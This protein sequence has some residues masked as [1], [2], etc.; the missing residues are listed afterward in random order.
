MTQPA[1]YANQFGNVGEFTN[2]QMNN[3]DA[4]AVTNTGSD[5]GSFIGTGS[6]HTPSTAGMN[7]TSPL[8]NTV[9][10]SSS[11][12]NVAGY[13]GDSQSNPGM[14]PDFYAQAAN[15]ATAQS[16]NYAQQA[17]AAYGNQ[18]PTIQNA[19][20]AQSRAQLAANQAGYNG[21]NR[22]LQQTIAG[23]GINAGQATQMQGQTANVAKQLTAANSGRGGQAGFNLG[24]AGGAMA[25][26]AQAQGQLSAQAAQAR[27]QQINAAQ[28]GLGSSLAGQGGQLMAQNATQYGQAL[29]QAQLQASQNQMNQGQ[30]LA[31]YNQSLGEQGTYLNASNAY[32][33][34]AQAEQGLTVKQQQINNQQ[35]NQVMGAI[36]GAASSG[37]ELATL[38]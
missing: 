6:G 9:A 30:A 26:G 29:D 19:S 37:L 33:N 24:N 11:V 12:N 32:I 20:G 25:Q 34:Q 23:G 1:E 3:A 14:N 31:L 22:G 27:G 28:G 10:G 35:N 8:A 18:A 4:G 16:Q 17:A 38:A 2:V 36:T 7:V 5:A 13:L 21:L 15:T